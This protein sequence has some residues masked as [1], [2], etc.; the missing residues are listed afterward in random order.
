M[1]PKRLEFDIELHE[2]GRQTA[3]GAPLD[4]PPEWSAEHLVLAALARCSVT[5]LRYHARRVGIEVEA[6]GRASGLVTKRDTDGRYAFVE[7]ELELEV[8]LDPEPSED[9]L[10]ELLAKA[11]RDCFV[12]ASLTTPPRYTWRVD[13][14]EV[15]PL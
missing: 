9:A 6:S 14:R 10:R 15:E 4:P 7:F 2:S 12:G 1:R 8:G 11:E 13:G 3:A 5:S